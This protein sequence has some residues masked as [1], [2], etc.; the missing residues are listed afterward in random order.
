M[1]ALYIVLVSFRYYPF[2]KFIDETPVVVLV[3][4]RYYDDELF[5]VIRKKMF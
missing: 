5:E 3:S 2:S 4:F 1:I